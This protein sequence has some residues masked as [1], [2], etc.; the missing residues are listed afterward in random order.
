VATLGVI[1]SQKI[2]LIEFLFLPF[3][4]LAK[5]HKQKIARVAAA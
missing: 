3:F 1:L 4:Q 2:Q 5:N